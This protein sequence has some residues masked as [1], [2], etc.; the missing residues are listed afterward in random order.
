MID[1]KQ[2][3]ENV[4][5][6]INPQ[7]KEESIKI[8]RMDT[9]MTNSTKM[10]AAIGETIHIKGDVSGSESLVIHGHVEGNIDLKGH[11]VT[12]GKNGNVEANIIANNIIVEGK[13]DG[14]MNG[15]EKVIIKESGNVHGNIISPRVTLED[16]ALFKGSIE[17]EP[18]KI[19]S[20]TQT[21]ENKPEI[22]KEKP[23]RISA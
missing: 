11:N 21:S 19:E 13:L 3:K 6:K 16:G 10:V 18:R 23:K 15:N 7:K 17:M 4:T 5:N 1:M 14:D 8:E 12:I 9:K 2:I 22:P 20:V